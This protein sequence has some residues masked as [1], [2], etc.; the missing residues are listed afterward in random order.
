[1]H[2]KRRICF[3][4]RKKRYANKMQ[5]VIHNIQLK[6]FSNSRIVTNHFAICTDCICKVTV[7]TFINEIALPERTN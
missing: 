5:T 1:M 6:P 7:K 3:V 4:C 2:I